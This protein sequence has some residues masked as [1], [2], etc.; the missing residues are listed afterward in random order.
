MA[1]RT[2]NLTYYY[3]CELFINYLLS[4]INL[5]FYQNYF[6]VPTKYIFV[7]L[8]PMQYLV[9]TIPTHTYLS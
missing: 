5:L 6:L 9:P 2:L 4:I 8:L 3:N 1:D 7:D